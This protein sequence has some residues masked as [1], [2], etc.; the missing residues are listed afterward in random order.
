MN[1]NLSMPEIGFRY[2]IAVLLAIPIILLKMTLL[3]IIPIYFI[4]TALLG[5]CPVKAL[6]TKMKK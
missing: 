1:Y 4:L 5:M 6:F 2:V 3:V